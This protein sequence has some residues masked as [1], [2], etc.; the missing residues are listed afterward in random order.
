LQ[1]VWVVA[2]EANDSFL[3]LG[4]LPHYFSIFIWNATFGGFAL[5]VVYLMMSLGAIRGLAEDPARIRLALAIVLGVVITGIGI[6]GSFYNVTSPLLIAP[7]AALAWGALGMA[8]MLLV[9]GREPASQV[10][11]DLHADAGT[12]VSIG[13]SRKGEEA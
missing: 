4:P 5:L 2:S 1:V 11:A 10:L 3:Q 9:K 13:A 12:D 7:W 6:F 8:Y